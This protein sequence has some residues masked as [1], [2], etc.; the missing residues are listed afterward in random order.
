MSDQRIQYTE[1]MVGAGHPSLA[2]TLNRVTLVEHNNDGT[3]KTTGAGV[4]TSFNNRTGAVMP[5]LNS[6]SGAGD[7]NRND[8]RKT[9]IIQRRGSF[10]GLVGACR[11]S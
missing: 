11:P 3:H 7:I 2:D 4:V 5:A 1:K 8:N 9:I 10:T 6:C